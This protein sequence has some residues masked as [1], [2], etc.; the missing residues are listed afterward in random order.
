VAAQAKLCLTAVP[1]AWRSGRPPTAGVSGRGLRDCGPVARPRRGG[2]WCA[3]ACGA[4]AS[5]GTWAPH[6]RLVARAS[7]RCRVGTRRALAPAG[8][9]GQGAGRCADP[10]ISRSGLWTIGATRAR[11]RAWLGCWRTGSV[12]C[13]RTARL[14][15]R[16]A[17]VGRR[18][19]R[20]RW[21][22]PTGGRSGRGSLTRSAAR[23]ID[24]KPLWLLDP[25]CGVAPPGP[26]ASVHAPVGDTASAGPALR[27]EL[28][29]S[30]ALPRGTAPTRA[31][32]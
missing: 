30:G 21:A 2:A 17:P 5:E 20:L 31:V 1:R 3:L 13:T 19:A 24:P 28:T 16:E 27:T 14:G 8:R 18:C 11:L 32:G 10:E 23:F 7:G 22:D 15:C 26:P 12:R 9:L 4:V 25:G 29:A 6:R